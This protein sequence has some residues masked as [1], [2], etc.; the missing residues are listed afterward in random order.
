MTPR[1][2]QILRRAAIFTP[3]Y[4]SRDSAVYETP[5]HYVPIPIPVVQ[6]DL[7]SRPRF[8]K[9]GIIKAHGGISLDNVSTLLKQGNKDLIPEALL[10]EW[11]VGKEQAEQA[12]RAAGQTTYEYYGETYTVI[13]DSVTPQIPASIDIPTAGLTNADIERMAQD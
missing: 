1:Q 13:P 2:R 3:N 7:S 6:S 10:E 4:V 12:A 9:G 11:R 5:V 8:K